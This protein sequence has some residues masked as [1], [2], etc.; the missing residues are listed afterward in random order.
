VDPELEMDRLLE[1]ISSK[2]MKSLSSSERAS[3][4]N[5][6]QAI[7]VEHTGNILVSVKTENDDVIIA[8]ADNGAGIPDEIIGKMFQPY[9]TTKTSGTGLGLAMTKKIIE[10]WKGAIWFET[11]EGIGTTFYI[12]LP[13]NP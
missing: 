8:L 13:L 1:K 10:F 7:P 6:R 2:G 9:F 5:A 3:L 12:K 11:K 4:E